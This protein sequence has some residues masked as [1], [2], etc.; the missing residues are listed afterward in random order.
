MV[1]REDSPSMK[2]TM[3]GGTEY[4]PTN[5]NGNTKQPMPPS[6]QVKREQS[7][8]QVPVQGV[9]SEAAM[10]Q[11]TLNNYFKASPAVA[12]AAGEAAHLYSQDFEM[13][14][15]L[16][17]RARRK[18]LR[19]RVTQLRWSDLEVGELLGKGNFSH[20]YEV[21]LLRRRVDT[22]QDDESVLDDRTISTDI[23]DLA[24]CVTQ[25]TQFD[26]HKVDDIWDLVS[27]SGTLVEVPE[28]EE[29]EEDDLERTFA[30][31]HLHPGAMANEKE[32][33][34]S[35]IDLVLE[36]KLLGNLNHE[37]VIKLHAVTAGSIST[38]FSGGGF[39]L[40]LDR[41][42]ET[43]EDKIN[44]WAKVQEMKATRKASKFRRNRAANEEARNN[45]ITLEERI[46]SCALGI[47]R[48]MEYLHSNRIIF[49]DLKPANVGFD[50]KGEVK[51]FD[52]GLAREVVD[53]EQRMT[54][55]TGSLRY[56]APEVARHEHYGLKADV[57]SFGLVLWEIMSCELPFET[58][59]RAEHSARVV[60][61]SERPEIDKVKQ[62]EDLRELIMNCWDSAPQKRPNFIGVRHHLLTELTQSRR[63]E[64]EKWAKEV[65]GATEAWTADVKKTSVQTS[66]ANFRN[67]LRRRSGGVATHSSLGYH[68][69]EDGTSESK[70]LGWS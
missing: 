61:G 5:A 10:R 70:K 48:G 28:E 42:T 55:N 32:F 68:R 37:N 62:S 25:M 47:A 41:L 4:S 3:N 20:V 65:K 24:S 64:T 38:V 30:L 36:A 60:Y 58:L 35:A 52:F 34:A 18:K 44:E 17:H 26:H 6:Y 49:R 54:G 13:H 69:F 1:V 31:K 15:K 66:A 50:E 33:K 53:P 23:W 16:A 14:S 39:F 46:R 29:E 59:N 43:L 19:Q 21:K 11:P 51:I 56:M 45:M 40:L 27:H 2:S 22:E 8:Q 12:R 67:R 7:K 9:P 63:L 57:Y